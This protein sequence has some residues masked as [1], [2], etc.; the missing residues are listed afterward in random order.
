MAY[1]SLM[2]PFLPFPV[3]LIY[4]SGGLEIAGGIGVMHPKT[5]RAAGW[6]LIALLIAVFPANVHAVLTGLRVGEWNVPAWMLWA[7]LPL[8]PLLIW[9][10]V[11]VTGSAKD[12][13]TDGHVELAE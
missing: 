4:L 13:P 8:Q 9:W 11:R 12:E 6:G 2:P 1:V 7:R 5:R 3:A 10:V